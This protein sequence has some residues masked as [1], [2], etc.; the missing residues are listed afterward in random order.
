M[1]KMSRY[2]KTFKAGGKS[3]KLISFRI[4]Y[5]K[6]LEKYKIIWAKIE[7]LK[8]IKLKALPVYYDRYIKTEI[9]TYGDKVYTNFRSLNVPEFFTCVRKTNI[10]FKYI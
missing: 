1:S 2:V 3:I 6:L 7:D 10:T 9:R 8:N 4:D 5:E